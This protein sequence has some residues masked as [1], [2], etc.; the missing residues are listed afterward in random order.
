[1]TWS[2]HIYTPEAAAV[3]ALV[4]GPSASCTTHTVLSAQW[5]IK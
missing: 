4:L 1:M 3:L 2:T 5:G